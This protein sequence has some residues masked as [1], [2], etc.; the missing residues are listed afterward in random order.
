MGKRE[1]DKYNNGKIFFDNFNQICTIKVNIILDNIS[2]TL[3]VFDLNQLFFPL[4]CAFQY[5]SKL[6]KKKRLKWNVSF[7]SFYLRWMSV[8]GL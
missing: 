1:R 8:N 3:F 2:I 7:A 5:H 4:Q 6:K